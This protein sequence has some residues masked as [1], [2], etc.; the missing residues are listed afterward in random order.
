MGGDQSK[1]V[2]TPMDIPKVPV[3]KKKPLKVVKNVALTQQSP[4]RDLQPESRVE[5]QVQEQKTRSLSR[6]ASNQQILEHVQQYQEIEE[7][8]E[9]DQQ[10][11]IN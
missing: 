2:L 4:K 6:Q 3:D 5:Q 8:P 1:P 7:I 10:D 9:L 11:Q